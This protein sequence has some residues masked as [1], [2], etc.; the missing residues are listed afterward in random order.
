MNYTFLFSMTP[1]WKNLLPFLIIPLDINDIYICPSPPEESCNKCNLL[2]EGEF[3]LTCI[4]CNKKYHLTCTNKNK[5]YYHQNV[6]L[7]LYIVY[8]RLSGFI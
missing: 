1:D 2:I 8:Y 6:V 3:F 7:Y 5:K 4:D